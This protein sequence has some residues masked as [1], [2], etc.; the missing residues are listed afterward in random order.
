MIGIVYVTETGGVGKVKHQTKLP[1]KLGK[2]K[3]QF[4]RKSDESMTLISIFTP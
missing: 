3:H 1:G 2:Q 4:S